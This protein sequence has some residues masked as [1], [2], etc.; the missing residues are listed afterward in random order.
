MKL[1]K[2]STPG[3]ALA[4]LLDLLAR[5]NFVLG[6]LASHAA[7]ILA[8]LGLLLALPHAFASNQAAKRWAARW[9]EQQSPVNDGPARGSAIGAALDAVTNDGPARDNAVGA[10]HDAA[11]VERWAGNFAFA[12]VFSLIPLVQFGNPLTIVS[13]LLALMLG[14]ALNSFG[15]EKLTFG[16][17]F[18]VRHVFY[19]LLYAL[20]VLVA[21]AGEIPFSVTVGIALFV[22]SWVLA[23]VAFWAPDI[24]QLLGQ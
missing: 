5:D 16:L 13:A 21:L 18:V 22:D 4:L 24:L 15:T 1:L 2:Y 12:I 9:A 6:E 20:V 11:I 10:A 19:I 23:L 17:L 7:F 8:L 14:V 3:F